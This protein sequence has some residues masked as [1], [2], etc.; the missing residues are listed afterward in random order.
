MNKVVFVVLVVVGVV[1]GSPA[2]TPLT[3]DDLKDKLDNGEFL[4]FIS[5]FLIKIRIEM[6]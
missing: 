2:C 5:T 6:K 3:T 4:S 1:A